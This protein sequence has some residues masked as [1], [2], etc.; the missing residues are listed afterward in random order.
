MMC[1]MTTD[2]PTKRH[3]VTLTVVLT[4]LFFSYTYND[5]IIT[6]LHGMNV[7]SALADGRLLDF[8]SYNEGVTPD[9]PDF[10]TAPVVYGFGLYIVFAI[11]NLPL[12]LLQEFAGVNV[13]TSVLA[14]SWAKAI[15]V[16]FL[17][18]TAWLVGR[19]CSE[20]GLSSAWAKWSRFIY[21]T[22]GFLVAAVFVM[23]QYDVIHVFFTLLGIYYLIQGR[24][25]A[26]VAAFAVAIAMKFFP[27]F[28]FIPVLLLKEKRPTRIVLALVGA[29]SLTVLLRVPFLFGAAQSS[30]AGSDQVSFMI[31]GNRLPVGL[32]GV[33]VFPVLFALVCIACYL[34]TPVDEEDSRRTSIYA[35]FAGAAAFFVSAPAFPYWFA[36]L[37]PFIV[38]LIAMNPA[39]ARAN[40][41]IE[42]GM[43]AALI[44]VHQIHFYWTYDLSVVRPMAIAALFGPV[45]SLAQPINPVDA[46]TRLGVTEYKDL[47]AAVFVAG[48]VALLVIN[49]P[50]RNRAPAQPSTGSSDVD[51]PLV[52]VRA[53]VTVSL[54][55]VPAAA[56]FYSLLAHGTVG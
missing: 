35:G 37:C 6:T 50:S 23:A 19:I 47:L 45:E 44:V 1:G 38:L 5:N 48:M 3:W 22:S 31:M 27:L 33:P 40:V 39:R 2:Q 46:Y 28:V 55:L 4:G 43:T 15:T 42:T 18:G 13:F 29:L 20:L 51:R 34:Y 26:F 17:L 52:L 30:A 32:S 21:L 56:Y 53:G 16:P 25:R 10:H 54:C 8:Y 41:L 9:S 12:W 14:L 11:W 24:H 7:W 49:H 36:M